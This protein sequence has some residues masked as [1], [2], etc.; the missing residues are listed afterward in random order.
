[1]GRSN[2]CENNVWL[3]VPGG[4]G[5]GAAGG[6]GGGEGGAER[7]KEVAA[8]RSDLA[9]VTR[10]Q[11]GGGAWRADLLPSLAALF[12]SHELRGAAGSAVQF[13]PDRWR[14]CLW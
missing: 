3:D 12:C 11:W 14:Q 9:R 4:G 1:M 8:R 2:V 5:G 6:G 10:R 7:V 13:G